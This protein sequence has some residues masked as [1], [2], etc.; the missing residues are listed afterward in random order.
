MYCLE[1]SIIP[2]FC[3]EKKIETNGNTDYIVLL[4]FYETEQKL[5]FSYFNSPY[6]YNEICNKLLTVS[7][8]L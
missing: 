1:F 5:K 6:F 7:N 2:K 3:G 4:H 8:K